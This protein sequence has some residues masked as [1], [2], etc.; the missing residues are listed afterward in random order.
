MPPFSTLRIRSIGC[1][2]WNL[3]DSRTRLPQTPV[4]ASVDA[5]SH[6]C[7]MPVP[8]SVRTDVGWKLYYDTYYI[9][10]RPIKAFLGHSRAAVF[11]WDICQSTSGKKT[12]LSMHSVTC[13]NAAT[14][15]C[16]HANSSQQQRDSKLWVC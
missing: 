2:F 14:M 12:W 16:G 5:R 1:P 7:R 11:A 9:P 3:L 8:V 15:G 6:I 13:W 10:T 4:R